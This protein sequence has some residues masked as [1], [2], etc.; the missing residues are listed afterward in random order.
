M[1][2]ASK[3]ERSRSRSGNRKRTARYRRSACRGAE[4]INVM[5][6]YALHFEAAVHD[7]GLILL[8]RVWLQPLDVAQDGRQATA[9]KSSDQRVRESFAL[10]SGSCRIWNN[11]RSAPLLPAVKRGRRRGGH[12]SGRDGTWSKFKIQHDDLWVCQKP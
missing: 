11:A 12:L 5:I 9:R 4:K 7:V 6:G 2:G 3:I 1:A 8:A 10:V